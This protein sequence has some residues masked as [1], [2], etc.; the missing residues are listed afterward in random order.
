MK[1]SDLEEVVRDMRERTPMHPDENLLQ[2]DARVFHLSLMLIE[3]SKE[4]LPNVKAV[5]ER[6]KQASKRA[7]KPEKELAE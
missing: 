6:S 3:Q 1:M 7:G 5:Q 2:F 4:E